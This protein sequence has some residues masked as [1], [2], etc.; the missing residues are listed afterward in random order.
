MLGFHTLWTAPFYVKN[1]EDTPYS[2]QDYEVL[3]M[4]LSAIMW[5]KNNGPIV[6]YG[7]RKAL[8]YIDSL[9]LSFIWNG[10]IKEIKVSEK[11]DPGVFWAA[12]KLFALK[13]VETPAVMVDLDLIIWK[14]IVDY[15]AG[16]DLCA[17]HREGLFPEVY[18]DIH[19]LNMKPGYSFDPEWS[20]EVMPVNTCMLYMG[21]GDLKKYYVDSAIDFMENCNEH[22]DNLHHMV[23][24]EQ[25]LL[26]MCAE[27]YGKVVS[28]FFP[29][30]MDIANQDIFT[31]LWGYKNILK[32]N[33]EEREKFVKKMKDR[34][35]AECPECGNMIVDIK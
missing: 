7:D 25:R 17:I 16:A 28:S 19:T 35:V 20:E 4:I 15:V 14:R 11:I 30:S 2:M 9:G 22:E 27:K 21:D 8:E 29:A 31:H 18:P 23:F 33:Y 26:A 10:G 13:E 1:S 24:A 5:R 12:A 6:L 3:T 32:F 34:I